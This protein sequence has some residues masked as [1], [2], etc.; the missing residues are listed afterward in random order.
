MGSRALLVAAVLSGTLPFASTAA[1][2]AP[3]A[4]EVGSRGPA[5]TTTAAPAP[6][7][8]K[9]QTDFV[10]TRTDG[11]PFGAAISPNSRFGI[12]SYTGG[13]LVVYSLP[14]PQRAAPR[15]DSLGSYGF[16][17]VTLSSDGRYLLAAVD[18]GALVLDA[19]ALE[20]GNLGRDPGLLATLSTNGF[21]GAIEVAFSPGDRYAFVTLEARDELAV[22]NLRKALRTG[23]ARSLVGFV[24]LESAPVGIAVSPEGKDLYVTS[25]AASGTRTAG[26]HGTLTT[27]N[28]AKAERHPASSVV[29][30]VWAGC[31]PVRVAASGANVYVTARGSDALLEFNAARLVSDPARALA[32]TVQVG[33]A[34]V[35]LAVT[36]AGQRVVVADSDRFNSPGASSNLAIVEVSAD[37]GLVLRGY[38]RSGQFP[39]DLAA[40]PDSRLVL[41]ACFDSD[42]I[43]TVD[44]RS[45]P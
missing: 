25:E 13:P 2:A 41:V 10:S 42:R 1:Q 28:I 45:L 30:T 22:F 7:L 20:T 35:G 27:V 3:L 12:V 14:N 17:G 38:V 44:A 4:R 31:S 11:S 21:N 23:G 8:M 5:C 9:V 33:E 15:I 16:A 40:S 18:D 29:S 32:H 34:P 6:L 26:A 43:E 36:D 39:R 19:T 24:P 37:G